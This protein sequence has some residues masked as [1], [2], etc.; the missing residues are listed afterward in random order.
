MQRQHTTRT[1]RTARLVTSVALAGAVLLGACGSDDDEPAAEPAAEEP[2]DDS[3]SDSNSDS[4]DDSSSDTGDGD[5]GAA[6]DATSGGDA[7]VEGAAELGQEVADDILGAVD[8]DGTLSDAIS[9]LS[10]ETR[11][12]AVASQLDPEPEIVVDGTTIRFV[13]PGGTTDDSMMS[14]IIAGSFVEPDETLVLEYPDG[15]VEC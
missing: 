3:S 5:A 8:E 7:S 2:A 4:G 11:F 15:E 10:P 1:N 14:C 6:G 9:S 13:F 12:G